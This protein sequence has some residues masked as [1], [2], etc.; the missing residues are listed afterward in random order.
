[1]PNSLQTI[2]TEALRISLLLLALGLVRCCL[3]LR[4][5]VRHLRAVGLLPPKKDM[6]FS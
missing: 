4:S 2:A 3:A 1:M 6:A 5:V